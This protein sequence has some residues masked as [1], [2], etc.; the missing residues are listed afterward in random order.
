MP[1]KQP[2]IHPTM[3]LIVSPMQS[4]I[5]AKQEQITLSTF[6]SLQTASASAVHL[7]HDVS[8]EAKSTDDHID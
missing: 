8:R 7:P 2:A 3:A 1:S 5:A 4:K 6:V